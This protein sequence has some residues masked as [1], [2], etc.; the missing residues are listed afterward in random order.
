ML[1]KLFIFGLLAAPLCL[2]GQSKPSKGVIDDKQL[3]AESAFI[4][5]M[6]EYMAENYAKSAA[7]FQVIINKYDPTPG[8]YHM[9]TKSHLELND[10]NHA[11]D[12][13]KSALVLDKENAYYQKYYASILAK[14]YNY[15][16]AIDLYKKVIKK[17]PLDITSYILLSDIYI[18]Q[19]E[20]DQ[21]IKL[22][23]QVEKN[24]GDD[25]EI[26][27]RKQMLYLKQNKVDEAIKEGN[28]L[29]ENQPLEPDYVLNQAQI[30]IGNQKLN[31]AKKLLINYLKDDPNLAEGRVLLADIYRRQGDLEAC[32]KELQLAFDNKELE[33]EIKLKVLG[34]YNKLI[35]DTPST[36]NLNSAI[37]LTQKLI[38]IEPKLAGSYVFMGDLL[39]KKGNLREARENYLKSTKYDKSVFEVWLALVELDTKLN[40][41]DALVKD[42][43]NASDYF[44]NQA[45]F[46]YHYGYGNVLKKEYNE[47]IYALEEAKALAFDNVEL[48]KHISSLLGDSFHATKRYSKAYKAYDQVLE[49]DPNYAPVL[50]N[51]SYF[52]AIE[53]KDLD[54]AYLLSGRLLSLNPDNIEY[55]DTHGWVL[56][57]Q[58]EY[59]AAKTIIE[60][61]IKTHTAL[62]GTIL[63]HYGDILYK[64]G[65]VT[66]ALEQWK[67]A[68]ELGENSIYIDSKILKKQYI[69]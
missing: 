23:N 10:L 26:S 52:L 38:D 48:S 47:A 28:R 50:N 16:E 19:E 40:D 29:I 8:M 61:A 17:N 13:A 25:E 60:K 49:L 64:L 21:A 58:G 54:K 32:N 5:G 69:E 66:L 18:N 63:E 7:I 57:Q 62:N 41:T 11:A 22:Y 65:E 35:E 20:Y 9:L 2:I 6:K 27:N 67:K 37:E 36:E 55:I 1:K 33:P 34:S 12:A 51:Y 15:R 3:A 68:K 53:K 39:M 14:Q 46:W 30:M 24:I 44:P 43:Q 4:E 45:F 31:D 42:A 56:F 59:S